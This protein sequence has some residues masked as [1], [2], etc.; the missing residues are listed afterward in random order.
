MITYLIKFIICSGVLL[1]FYHIALQKDRLFKFNR[2]YLLA[3]LGLSLVIPVTIVRTTYVEVPADMY[4]QEYVSENELANNTVEETFF[5][6]D[7]EEN[8]AGESNSQK[9]VSSSNIIWAIYLMITGVL[10]LRYSRN[11][12][13][14]YWLKRKAKIVRADGVKIALRSDISTSFSFMNYMFTNKE[15]FEQGNL[16]A[17]IIAHEKLHINDKHS[18]DIIFIEFM[19]C[20]FWFNPIIIFI[21]KAIKLN[22]EFLADAYA[23]NLSKSAYAYQKILLEY[24]E[25]QMLNTPVLASNLNY[26]FTKKRLNMMTK[27]TNRIL[28]LIKPV[29]AGLIIFS[30]F[31]VLGVTDTVAKVVDDQTTTNEEERND[32]EPRNTKIGAIP[33]SD[34]DAQPDKNVQ[35]IKLPVFAMEHSSLNDSIGTFKAITFVPTE[36]KVRFED[37]NGKIVEKRYRLLN[38]LEKKQFWKPEANGMYFREPTPRKPISQ[39]ELDE[40][41]DGKVYGIWLDN[42]KIKNAELKKYSPEDIHH[43]SKS[44]L[45]GRAKASKD[46]SYQVN[47]TT[48]SYFEKNDNPNGLWVQVKVSKTKMVLA[49]LPVQDQKDEHRLPPP[50]F[51]I[52]LIRYKGAEGEMIVKK[53]NELSTEEKKILF[54][55]E[56]G[57]EYFR[58]A[59]AKMKIDQSLLNQFLDTKK[60]RI[61]VDG[62]QIEN[63]D[64]KNYSPEE[65]HHYLKSKLGKNARNF[66]KYEYQLDIYT[67]KS[68]KPEGEW[69]TFNDPF[70]M[71]LKDKEEAKELV[72]QIIEVTSKDKKAKKGN[73]L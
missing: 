60:Y 18:L 27:N 19:Q 54:K 11:L 22:H 43:F 41:L 52:K 37:V 4:V 72:P 6:S 53:L 28:S 36:A 39:S 62:K 73:N 44:R 2:F 13:A 47:L 9:S 56:S 69:L 34:K 25:K 42:Y 46:Y 67:V 38:D 30:A 21:K 64:L 26:G 50:P 63:Q 23:I 17:E 15:R 31:M 7:L 35:F 16:P 70:Y 24:T 55:K 48:N 1:L 12:V 57:A 8:I 5:A 45:L 61:W 20:I 51:L 10:C 49:T 40:F 68:I 32:L 33:K 14:I 3:I 66:G 29:A 59:P 58:P 65:L 71:Q